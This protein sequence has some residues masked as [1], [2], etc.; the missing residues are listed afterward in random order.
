MND[1]D[2]RDIWSVV[3]NLKT[4]VAQTNANTQAAL[5]R[6]EAM[7]GERCEAR[8]QK[9]NDLLKKQDEHDNRLDK[10]E[11]LRAQLLVLAAV[12]SVI[13]GGIVGWFFRAFGG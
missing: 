1:Q 7:L 2:A 13:G 3:N 4:E 5:A 12:G 8:V 9:I 11:Q 10:L 6:I